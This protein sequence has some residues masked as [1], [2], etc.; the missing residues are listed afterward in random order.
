VHC[1]NAR[2]NQ[3]LIGPKQDWHLLANTFGLMDGG[4]VCGFGH[5]NGSVRIKEFEGDK[6]HLVAETLG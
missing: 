1:N 6:L 3:W 4:L 5:Q 2:I